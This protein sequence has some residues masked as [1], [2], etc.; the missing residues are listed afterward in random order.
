MISNVSTTIEMECYSK[1]YGKERGDDIMARSIYVA[2]EPE[3][4]A[5]S[6]GKYGDKD[7]SEDTKIDIIFDGTKVRLSIDTKDIPTLRALLNSYL[8][9]IDAACRSLTI[10]K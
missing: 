8:R 4:K 6:K 10:T 3:C 2:L 9:F 1:G 5:S 7:K